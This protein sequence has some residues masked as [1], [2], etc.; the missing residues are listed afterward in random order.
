MFNEALSVWE[1]YN[2]ENILQNY[3]E[4]RKKNPH[5]EEIYYSLEAQNLYENIVLD[6]MF[7]LSVTLMD[8]RIKYIE[9][10]KKLPIGRYVTYIKNNYRAQNKDEIL[11]SFYEL[12]IIFSFNEENFNEL[13]LSFT[14]NN[15]NTIEYSTLIERYENIVN[16]LKYYEEVFETN[17]TNKLLDDFENNFNVTVNNFSELLFM[18]VN[19]LSMY[20]DV[21]RKLKMHLILNDMIL[22]EDIN[23]ADKEFSSIQEQDD[24]DYYNNVVDIDAYTEL[25]YNSDV[26]DMIDVIKEA[27]GDDDM[28]IGGRGRGVEGG[29]RRGDGGERRGDGGQV[30]QGRV[31]QYGG[32]W[33]R[34]GFFMTC[35]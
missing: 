34:G 16:Y 33:Q 8:A 30:G 35:S 7:D 21:I 28:Q 25:T 9:N 20:E 3:K 2:Y 13:L 29:E 26:I 31:Q 10:V 32:M 14:K 1:K 17:I 22:T 19:L 27:F 11:G 12:Q 4:K 15:I 18:R 23:S 6:N 5:F 24:F